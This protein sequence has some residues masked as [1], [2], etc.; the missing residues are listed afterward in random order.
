MLEGHRGVLSPPATVF[1]TS[2]EDVDQNAIHRAYRNDLQ[3]IGLL[4]AKFKKPKK[5]ELPEI[6]IETGMVKVQSLEITRLGRLLL[7]YIDLEESAE[8]GS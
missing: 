5:G 7:R 8:E 2:E 4:R 6:D 3:R 1:G